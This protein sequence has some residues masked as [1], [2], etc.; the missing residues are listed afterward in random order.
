MADP[1]LTSALAHRSDVERQP[2]LS[3]TLSEIRD[4][5]MID[6][7]GQADDAKFMAAAKSVLGIALPTE[8][9]SSATKNDMTVLWFSVDHWLVTLPN[10]STAKTLAALCKKTEGQFAFACDVS[11]ARAIIRIE[12]D[13]VREAL[14]KGTSL[15]LTAPEIETGTVRRMLFAEVAAACHVVDGTTGTFDLYVFRSYADYVW[16]WLMATTRAGARVQLYGAQEVPP[17]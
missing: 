5:G 7:R 8:P 2:G 10:G 15:D 11:D 9:R 13:G 3:V 14:M 12:G 6:L 17:V 4:R 16:E 1:N